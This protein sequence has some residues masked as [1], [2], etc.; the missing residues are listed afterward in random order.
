MKRQIENLYQA[1]AFGNLKAQAF[2]KLTEYVSRIIEGRFSTSGVLVNT[3]CDALSLD[4][5]FYSGVIKRNTLTFQIAPDNTLLIL[6]GGRIDHA[7]HVKK[8]VIDAHISLF[9][10]EQNRK[11]N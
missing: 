8:E 5:H 2:K 3:D 1:Q 9:L 6:S 4:M 11:V 10:F 7:E